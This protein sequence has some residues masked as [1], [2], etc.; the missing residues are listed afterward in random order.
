[1]V[2]CKNTLILSV[3]MTILMMSSYVYTQK[4]N[5]VKNI[6]AQELKEIL[7]EPTT[8]LIDVREA[9]ERREGFIDGSIHVPLNQITCQ[10]I[11]KNKKNIALYCRSGRRS[12][13]A[14][15]KL[16]HENPALKVWSLDGGI[17]AWK[18]AGFAVVKSVKSR[19]PIIQQTM[20]GAGAL[21]LLGIV[22]GTLVS[23]VFLTISAFVGIG[24]MVAGITGW[25]SM[26]M[27]LAKMPWNN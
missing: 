2:L 14:A 10:L 17:I 6:Q 19:L 7:A 4:E 16:L 22:L 23:P 9:T 15:E 20:L 8:L 25:C 13:I 27:L 18:E 3:T 12:H 5:V 21:V 1:M 24:L 11:P 26:S